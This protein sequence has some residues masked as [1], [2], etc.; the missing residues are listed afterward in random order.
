M[1]TGGPAVYFDG[2][3]T[4]RHNVT[5]ELTPSSLL[6]EAQDGRTLARWSYGELEQSSSQEGI[7]RI[8]RMNSDSLE[9]IEVRDPDLAKAIDDLSIPLDRSGM[10]QRRSRRRVIVL[11]MAAV[12]SLLLVGIFGIP[13]LATRLAPYVPYA[14]EKRVG[15]AVNAQ[16]RTVFG[17]KKDGAKFEC[18]DADDEKA[19]LAALGR[20]VGRMEQAAQLPLPLRVRVIRQKQANAI[21]LPGGYIYVFQGL[22]DQAENADEVAGV[23]AHEIGHVAN[24]DGMRAVLQA[25]GLSFLFGLVLGDFV[26]GGAVIIATRAVLQLAYSREAEASADLYAVQL[27]EKSGGDPRA[28]GTILKRIAGKG[29]DITILANHPATAERARTIDAA[30]KGTNKGEVLSADE[31]AALRKICGGT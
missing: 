27:V 22:I 1:T 4:Q 28:L 30:A 6:V 5:L 29:G 25:G 11:A 20:M 15:E 2:K 18:G 13:A 9:R 10:T 14:F 19:G 23:L 21:A 31:W 26:G 7:L 8:A 12:A 24:R 3:S 17:S 16:V